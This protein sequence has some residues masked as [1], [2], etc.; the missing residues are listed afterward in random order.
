MTD[1]FIKKNEEFTTICNEL[2]AQFSAKNKHYGNDYFEGNYSELERWLSIKRKVAR[3]EA[4]HKQG[5]KSNLPDETL[6]DTWKD[7]A[8][9][10]IMELML[11][12]GGEKK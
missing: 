12:K 4:H 11:L 7:L 5:I 3:I 8:I 1:K 6:I 2:L 9:Y 10:T